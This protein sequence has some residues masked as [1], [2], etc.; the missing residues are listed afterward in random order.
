MSIDIHCHVIGGGLDIGNADDDVFFNMDDN[1]H[2]VTWV[3]SHM[4]SSGLSELGGKVLNSR[5]ATDHYFELLVR[6]LTESA[7]IDKLVLLALDA[8][9][10]DGRIDPIKT[11]LYI[12]NRY[13]SRKVK[14]L[15]KA[16][17]KA[18]SD[19]RFFYGASISPNRRKTDWLREIDFVC[20]DKDAVLLKWIPS[21]QHI[22]I[23]RV[24][25][26]FFSALRET[27]LPLLCH[28]GPEYSFPEGIRRK[29]LD[30]VEHLEKPLSHDIKVIAA[31]C[32]AP[33][34]PLIDRNQMR[35]LAV[36]MEK[37]NA[38]GEVKLWADT[39]ALSLS[40]RLSCIP[41]ILDLFNPEWLVHGSDFPIPIEGWP[42]LP[43]VTTDI[44]P[45]EYKAICETK[46]P[47]DRDVKIKKAHGFA[48]SILGNAEKA[49]RMP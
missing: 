8:V 34:F 41:D 46:N 26:E 4:V 5:I 44:T 16:L 6:L 23:N 1:R 2:L 15:N 9:Y 14:D 11:D 31:H 40:T 39:S 21:A 45:A 22:E 24:K 18:G 33:V 43:I 7:L 17:K 3:V 12:S 32:A 27:G 30:M 25:D 10:E 35:K 48:E 13:L 47:F 20:C 38:R 42:H 49:L 36:M 28:V 19:K 29:E 37:N